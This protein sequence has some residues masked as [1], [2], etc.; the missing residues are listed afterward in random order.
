MIQL[1]PGV[2]V[3]GASASPSLAS[4]REAGRI[5]GRGVSAA[6][7]TSCA[8]S[9]ASLLSGLLPAAGAA[10]ATAT[11]APALAIAAGGAAPA[12]ATRAGTAGCGLAGRAYVAVGVAVGVAAGPPSPWISEK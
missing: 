1:R 6:V 11:G 3:G 4:S 7:L 2:G 8:C 12:L 9:P 10:L 5:W